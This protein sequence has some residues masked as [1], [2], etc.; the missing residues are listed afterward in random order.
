MIAGTKQP[1]VACP[2]WAVTLPVR[3]AQLTSD[4]GQEGQKLVATMGCSALQKESTGAPA[5]CFHPTLLRTPPSQP[6][7]LGEKDE[8]C[9]QRSMDSGRRPPPQLSAV[10]YCTPRPPRIL[11]HPCSGNTLHPFRGLGLRPVPT[12]QSHPTAT[13]FKMVIPLAFTGHSCSGSPGS[14]FSQIGPMTILHLK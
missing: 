9:S 3:S 11:I 7:E 10:I 14:T 6:A 8:C 5:V 1:A 4:Q 13:T 2:A 12:P